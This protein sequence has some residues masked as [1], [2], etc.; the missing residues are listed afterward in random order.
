MSVRKGHQYLNVF[1]A[2]VARRVLFATQ[3][4][5]GA[6]WAQ[7]VEALKKHHGHRHA[8]TPASMDMSAACQSGVAGHCRHAQVVFDKFHVIKNAHEAVDKVRRA[9]G[10][11]GGTGVGEA[12]HQSQWIWRKNPENLSE[13]EQQ[14]LS[15]IKDKN[16][17]TAKAYPM[18]RVLQD[19]YRSADARTARH[20]FQVWG[21]WVRWVARFHK[22]NVFVLMVKLAAMVGKHLAG[23]VAHWQWGVAHAFMEGLNTSSTIRRTSRRPSR[24]RSMETAS[25]PGS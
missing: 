6:T 21:R 15:G 4:K 2:L 9:E 25:C 17:C 23:R 14:H 13:Q 11:L 22:G 16:L 7:F 10:R 12:L 24:T 3:G 19:I 8:I 1:A 20:R 18:R 5:D